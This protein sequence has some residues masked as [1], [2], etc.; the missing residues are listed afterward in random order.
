MEIK[1][2]KFI[3]LNEFEVTIQ[4][5]KEFN[6]DQTIEL[7]AFKDEQGK[8]IE[9]IAGKL[10]VWAND[11]TKHKQKEVVFVEI[12]TPAISS[13]KE[14]KPVIND[15]KDRINQY[16]AQAYIKLSEHSD[17]VELD[18]T[19]EKDF[20]NFVTSNAIDN[21]KTSGGKNLQDYLI[22]KLENAYPKKYSKSF[23]AFYFAENGYS[24]SG[25]YVSGFSAA[26][27]DYVVVFKSRN[28]QTASHEFLHSMNLPHTFTN[29]QVSV[30]AKFTY[31]FSKTDNLLDYSHRLITR[32]NN[33]RCSLFYWQ[34]KQA[35][36]SIK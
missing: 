1:G 29:K 22:S 15:E 34:W 11:V 35:N 8:K 23:K 13:K 21:N 16:L 19:A 2:K 27:A 6:K 28:N 7:K 4:C 26:G 24:P 30:N 25:G 3:F 36:D 18:L 32:N 12:R 5:I 9:A 20:L 10:N 33:N 17:I 31:E 14:Q